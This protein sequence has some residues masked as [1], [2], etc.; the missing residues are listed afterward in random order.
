MTP[1]F[2]KAQPMKWVSPKTFRIDHSNKEFSTTKSENEP[3]FGHVSEL[4]KRL[5]RPR[6]CRKEISNQ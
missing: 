1:K 6:D 5:Y 3:Y 4:E 2:R